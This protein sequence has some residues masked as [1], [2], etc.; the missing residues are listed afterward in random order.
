MCVRQK[1]CLLNFVK[2]SFQLKSGGQLGAEMAYWCR[3][4]AVVLS[5][6]NLTGSLLLSVEC[7]VICQMQQLLVSMETTHGPFSVFSLS[8]CGRKKLLGAGGNGGI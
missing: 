6:V 4:G 7:P 8:L 1:P 3:C 2:Y 5:T